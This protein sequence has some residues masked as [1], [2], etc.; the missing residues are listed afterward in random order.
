M[1]MYHYNGYYTI[2]LHDCIIQWNLS[3]PDTLG[4]QKTVLII[5]VSLFHRFI[6]LYTFKIIAIGDHN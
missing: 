1:Y 6:N 3:I 2:K 4:P 5:E